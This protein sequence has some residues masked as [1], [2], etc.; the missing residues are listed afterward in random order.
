M[1]DRSY[2]LFSSYELK[3][4]ERRTAQGVRRKEE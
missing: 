3:V 1:P 2:V 4:K